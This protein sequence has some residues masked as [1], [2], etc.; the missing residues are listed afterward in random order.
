MEFQVKFHFITIIEPIIMPINLGSIVIQVVFL[1]L[2]FMVFLI[3]KHLVTIIIPI[4]NL[5]S[6]GSMINLYFTM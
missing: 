2:R 4:I 6:L 1:M 5:I 3:K